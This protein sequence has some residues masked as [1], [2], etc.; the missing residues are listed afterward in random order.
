MINLN[1]TTLVIHLVF[2]L[3]MLVVLNKLLFQPFLAVMDKR[4]EA[5]VGN[6]EEA[7]EA[8][9]KALTMKRDYE[10]KIAEARKSAAKE[11]EAIRKAGEAE[12]EKLVKDA[13]IKGGEVVADMQE[14]IASEFK[15]AQAALRSESES[16]G[17]EIASRI[18]GRAV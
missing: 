7:D 14:K 13:R 12:N 18:L 5:A 11:K 2:F 16:M 4:K 8:E 10:D 17:K 6:A 3:I 9:A 1:V 15:D